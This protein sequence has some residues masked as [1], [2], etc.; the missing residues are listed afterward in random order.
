MELSCIREAQIR[1][2]SSVPRFRMKQLG[3]ITQMGRRLLAGLALTAVLLSAAPADMARARELYNRTDYEA[4]LGLLLPPA[5]KDA[6]TNHLI[7]LCYYMQGDAKKASGYFEKAAA[8]EGSRAEYF[9]WLG[10]AYGRRAE[11]SSF[12]TAPG[13]ASKARENFER[14][15]QLDPRDLEAISDLFEFYLDAP[16]FLGGG[17]DKAAALAERMAAINPAE[18]HWAQARLAERRKQYGTAEQQLRSAVDLAPRQ[19]GRL[20]DL[21]KFLAKSGRY[22][23]S[24]ETFRRA[25]SLAPNSP[26]LMFERAGVYIRS[27]RNLE[28]AKQLLRRYLQSPLTPNDPPRWEAENLLKQVS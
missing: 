7:G 10:R 11:T 9:L 26:K 28:V 3:A 16:G 2:Y 8:Q 4:A 1:I 13:Y 19:V 25:E 15:V 6:A 17:L 14:A 5:E 12:V 22:Q 23:E 18:G 24:E 27:G 21:A 20:I